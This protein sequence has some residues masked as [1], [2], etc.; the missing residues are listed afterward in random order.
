[1]CIHIHFGATSEVITSSAEP[2]RRAARQPGLPFKP[3]RWGRGRGLVL[4]RPPGP[5]GGRAEALWPGIAG[6]RNEDLPASPA[7][8]PSRSG[9]GQGP[10]YPLPA[11]RELRDSLG[12]QAVIPGCCGAHGR[13]PG[14]EGRDGG[15]GGRRQRVAGP[16]ACVPLGPGGY[17]GV[18]QVLLQR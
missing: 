8:S 18:N 10:P 6:W 13:I 12:C 2:A 5:L 14:A 9:S 17:N 15:S 11:A 3:R 16:S 7:G 1:M 4:R